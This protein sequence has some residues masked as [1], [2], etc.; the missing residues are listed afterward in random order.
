MKNL[1]ITKEESVVDTGFMKIKTHTVE[2]NIDGDI[3]EYKRMCMYRG[4]AAFVIPYDKEKQCVI[5]VKQARIGSIVDGNDGYT[6]EFPAGIIDAGEVP[7]ESA[8]RELKEE[9]GLD[10]I[11]MEQ[12]YKN[13]VYTTIGGSNEKITYFLAEVDS[14]QTLEIAGEEGGNEYIETEIIPVED[15]FKKVFEE[16]SINTAAT[17]ISALLLKERLSK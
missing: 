13:P 14:S 11:N 1:K 10:A 15:L 5:M 2:E 9:T 7:I 8:T 3:K 17:M 6:L 4:N 12:I 16:G